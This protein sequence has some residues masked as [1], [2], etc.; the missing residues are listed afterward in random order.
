MNDREF[1]RLRKLEEDAALFEERAKIKGKERELKERIKAAK[2]KIKGKGF[3]DWLFNFKEPSRKVSYDQV[4]REQP[5]E[6]VTEV[7]ERVVTKPRGR[8]MKKVPKKV[9]K[10]V[11]EKPVVDRDDEVFIM[12]DFDKDYDDEFDKKFGKGL[13]I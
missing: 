12:P 10:K 2:K 7:V 3:F 11:V 13:G 8:P 1:Y 6:E 9:V 4:F 5:R